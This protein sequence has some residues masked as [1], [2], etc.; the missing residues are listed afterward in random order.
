[1]STLWLYRDV[2][3]NNILLAAD[4]SVRLADVG[5]SRFLPVNLT[6]VHSNT[7]GCFFYM[8]DEYNLYNVVSAALDV[9]R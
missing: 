7:Q 2:K 1:M 4:L 5:L 6:S 8:P 9:F 3:P